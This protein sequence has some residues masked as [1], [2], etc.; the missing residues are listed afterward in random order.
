MHTVIEDD[1]D[2]LQAAIETE[3]QLVVHKD[4]G[5]GTDV[6]L[7]DGVDPLLA[8]ADAVAPQ[9][10][11]GKMLRFSKGD[12]MTGDDIVAAGTKFTVNFDELMAGWIKW[13][14]NK[15]V[16]HA[17]VRVDDGVAPK[18]RI[19]LGAVDQ[20]QWT[21]DKSGNPRDPWQFTNYLPMMDDKGELFTFTTNSRGGI[22]AVAK[23]A[24]IYAKH[25]K[26][27]PNVL[28]LVALGVDSY[29]HKDPEYGR[30]KF[31][32]FEPAGYVPKA[33]FSAA[34]MVSGL[35]AEDVRESESV[36]DDKID[37]EIP[38]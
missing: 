29:K 20:S 1:N 25:R 23:M 9:Y 16:E 17:M 26:R 3:K 36:D 7:N 19:D 8:Y 10:I 5:G 18:R 4:N 30:I 32:V 12:W 24:R 2:E 13:V 27:H 14:N 21:V 28:P 6:A 37:D 35:Q 38:F 22:S 11:L 34:L 33:K 15:P 31:P